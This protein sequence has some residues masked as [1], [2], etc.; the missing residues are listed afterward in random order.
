MNF[1]ADFSACDVFIRRKI[2]GYSRGAQSR[3]TSGSTGTKTKWEKCAWAC[4]A[5]KCALRL[6]EETS[7]WLALE[8]AKAS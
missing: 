2:S 6:E 8:I 3:D 7:T 1:L 4:A 5:I